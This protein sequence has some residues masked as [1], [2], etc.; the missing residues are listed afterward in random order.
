MLICAQLYTLLHFFSYADVSSGTYTFFIT[1]LMLFLL[2]AWKVLVS[3]ALHMNH[4]NTC[5]S[6]C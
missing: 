5:Y 4:C 6:K 1:L 3:F 2:R